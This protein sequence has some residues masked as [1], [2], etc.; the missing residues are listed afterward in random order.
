[1]GNSVQRIQQQ[2]LEEF[3]RERELVDRKIGHKV[4]AI[5][6][7]N[8]SRDLYGTLLYMPPPH[9]EEM[10]EHWMDWCVIEDFEKGK[11]RDRLGNVI[12]TAHKKLLHAVGCRLT[13]VK[14]G[15][16]MVAGSHTE[17]NGLGFNSKSV[18]A[19]HNVYV[20]EANEEMNSL[21]YKNPGPKPIE[22]T[23]DEMNEAI[24]RERK[25]S[26]M[27]KHF[28]RS[29]M[30]NGRYCTASEWKELHAEAINGAW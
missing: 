13:A 2:A 18:A 19:A 5:L 9:A 12:N 10:R 7:K 30:A 3:E 21:K 22:K 4:S 16:A 29:A 20:Q 8:E 24:E 23:D 11:D 1:M 28:V 14:A 15:G 27:G 6:L 26:D 25:A 17:V